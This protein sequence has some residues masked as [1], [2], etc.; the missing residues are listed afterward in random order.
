MQLNHSFYTKPQ[1]AS[2]VIGLTDY[3]GLEIS[4]SSVNLTEVGLIHGS[5]T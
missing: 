3:F 2:N 4:Q 1:A 5:L